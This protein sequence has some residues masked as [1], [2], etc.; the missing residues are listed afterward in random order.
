MAEIDV[1]AAP[2]EEPG[3]KCTKASAP[4]YLL[5]AG[6]VASAICSLT[7]ILDLMTFAGP[8]QI[9]LDLYIVLFS[10]LVLSAE[11]RVFK[12]LRGIIYTWMKFVY[13]LTSYVGRGLFYFFLGSLVLSSTPLPIIAGSYTMGFGLVTIG[14]GLGFRLP[15]YLDWQVVQE[16]KKARG[17]AAANLNTPTAAQGSVTPVAA[18]GAT[19]NSI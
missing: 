19:P 14:V 6:F 13:F 16:E 7:A 4:T 12:P 2:G 5:I 9:V 18:A 8:A 15:V 10:I 3:C 11:L 1:N 17:A